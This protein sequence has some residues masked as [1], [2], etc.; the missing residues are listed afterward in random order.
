MQNKLD[1]DSLMQAAGKGDERA[2]NRIVQKYSG[3]IYNYVYR[4]IR[5][6]ADAEE[7]TSETFW[8]VWKHS[9]KWQPDKAKLSTWLYTIANNLATD[10]WRANKRKMNEISHEAEHVDDSPNQE[11]KTLANSQLNAVAKLMD[12]LPIM[13]KQALI[14]MVY[15]DKTIAEIAI[16]LGKTQGATEQLI[17]RARREMREKRKMLL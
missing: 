4:Y 5:I 12:A 2:F 6:E 17:I 11:D 1:D 3:S 15:D 9:P 16:I 14:L 10:Y 8:R 13:Q 7:I